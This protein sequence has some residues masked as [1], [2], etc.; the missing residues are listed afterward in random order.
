MSERA[1]LTTGASS[2]IGLATAI[3]VARRGLRSIG[4]V[5][6]AAKAKVVR[7]AADAAGVEVETVRLDVTDAAG[8]QRVL[9]GLELYGLV[10]N[11]GYS[12]TGAIEDVSDEE[13]RRLFET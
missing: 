12:L 13:A 7:T 10:N 4:T 2:G 8:C 5:R 3:E 9:A 11:A 6:S 1:V